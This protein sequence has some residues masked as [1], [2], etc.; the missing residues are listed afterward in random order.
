MVGGGGVKYD[1]VCPC[2]C[3]NY[4]WQGKHIIH[5][6]YSETNI[7]TTRRTQH[8]LNHVRKDSIN[9]ER[10]FSLS[11]CSYLSVRLSLSPFVSLSLSLSR[12]R[13]R[14]LWNTIKQ[15]LSDNINDLESWVS[16]IVNR[17]ECSHTQIPAC[18]M[19]WLAYVYD[20]YNKCIVQIQLGGMSY[21]RNIPRFYT[22]LHAKTRCITVTVSIEYNLVHGDTVR[23]A[24]IDL[25]L[26]RSYAICCLRNSDRRKQL[27]WDVYNVHTYFSM[28]V[29]Y[30]HL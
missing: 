9:I 5:T 29:L 28:I 10:P 15:S 22:C 11:L 20:P 3:I 19:K 13:S 25:T 17:R 26:S 27:Y 21:H 24:S 12:S 23:S 2:N 1:N 6:R 16:V 8:W 14:S 30:E 7:Y 4:G 18:M